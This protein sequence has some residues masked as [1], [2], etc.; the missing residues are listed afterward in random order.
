MENTDNLSTDIVSS[1]VKYVDMAV[2]YDHMSKVLDLMELGRDVLSNRLIP[3]T[4]G[5]RP[6]M[7]KI[8]SAGR[9]VE[10]RISKRDEANNF[11][12]RIGTIMD[13]SVYGRIEK[14]EGT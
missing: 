12:E 10:N 5:N 14:D 8:N 2:N 1:M 9:V 7:E 11:M 6:L 4:K 13:I 3:Q